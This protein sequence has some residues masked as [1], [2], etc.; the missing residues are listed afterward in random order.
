V[1]AAGHTVGTHTWSHVDLSNKSLE[2]AK[3]EIEKGISAVSISM[4]N[5]PVAP[6]FRFPALRHPPELVK[7]MAKRNIGIFSTD[8]DSFDFKMRKPEQVV[9]SVMKKLEKR[10]KGIIL[11]HDF[12]QATARGAEDLLNKLKAGGYKVVQITGKTP[13][14]PIKQ[15][16]EIVLKEIGGGLE[17]ARPMSS[18]I[19]TISGN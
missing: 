7:Y 10:G 2:D 4:G 1:I 11:M 8:M 15:Y 12:Q 19:K 14:E 9:A 6:F 18:V 16:N 17:N 5:K 13:T 3:A